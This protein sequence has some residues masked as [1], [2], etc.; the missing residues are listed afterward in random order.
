MDAHG[1][2]CQAGLRARGEEGCFE[3]LGRETFGRVGIT[4]GFPPVVLPVNYHFPDGAI[5]FRTGTHPR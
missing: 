1:D 4:L 2:W 5:Y 3:L